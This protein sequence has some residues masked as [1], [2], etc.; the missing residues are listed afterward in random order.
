MI[1]G[2]FYDPPYVPNGLKVL[3]AVELSVIVM[4]VLA[5]A[6]MSVAV[7]RSNLTT[8][9]S[10]VILLNDMMC[11]MG[12]LP[13]RAY[14]LYGLISDDLFYSDRTNFGVRRIHD[15]FLSA[16]Y[17]TLGTIGLAVNL[18]SRYPKCN[19]GTRGSMIGL[20][21]SVAQWASSIFILQLDA[22]YKEVQVAIFF[23][24]ALTLTVS[25]WAVRAFRKNLVRLYGLNRYHIARKVDI[26][27][28]I[29]SLKTMQTLL[30][31]SA[32]RLTICT[33]LLAFIVFYQMAKCLTVDYKYTG[34]LHDILF[35][36]F[37]VIIPVLTLSENYTLRMKVSCSSARIVPMQNAL[38]DKI[39]LVNNDTD[40]HFTTLKNFWDAGCA[41]PEP[42]RAR[43]V[44]TPE[45]SVGLWVLSAVELV[46]VF[47]SLSTEV[48]FVVALSR[49][50][51]LTNLS[52]VLLLNECLCS[53]GSLSLRLITLVNNRQFSDNRADPIRMYHDFFVLT[54]YNMMGL[55]GIIIQVTGIV[56][57]PKIQM[58]YVFAFIGFFSVTTVSVV[59][60]IPF[61]R[62]L[63]RL[64]G[65]H[66]FDLRNKTM[67]SIQL[68]SLSIL[69]SALYLSLARLYIGA[70][71]LTIIY[72]YLAPACMMNA[73]R[74]VGALHDII[75]E[76]FDTIIPFWTLWNEPLLR[77]KAPCFSKRQSKN[78]GMRNALGQKISLSNNGDRYFEGLRGMWK[79]EGLITLVKIVYDSQYSY[80][81]TDPIRMY[82][83]FFV[84]TKYNMMGVSGII[85]YLFSKYTNANFGR[86]GLFYGLSCSTSAWTFAISGNLGDPQIQILYV[87]TL[88]GVFS[89]TTVSVMLTIPFKRHLSRLY[90]QHKFDL[91]SKTMIS[92]QLRSLSILKSALYL[93]LARLYIGAP[94]LTIIY[95]YMAPACMITGSRYVG[96]LHDIIFESFDTIIPFW[97]LWN[98]PLLR[99]KA[100]CFSRRRNKDVG[101][102]NAL[103]QKISL[104]N[105]GDKHFEEL[106]GM[107]ENVSGVASFG[108]TGLMSASPSK[109]CC[110]DSPDDVPFNLKVVS[111]IEL[112]VVVVSLYTTLIFTVSIIRY[113]LLTSLSKVLLLNE[114]FCSFGYL[115][116]RLI[117]LINVVFNSRYTYSKDDRMG[118]YHDFFVCSKY[119]MIAISG[120]MLYIFCKFT[121]SNFGCKGA[122]NGLLCTLISWVLSI[123][124]LFGDSHTN[125]YHL[126]LASLMFTVTAG[127]V[128]LTI[129]FK[130]QL[131]SL[132]FQHKFDLHNKTMISIQLRSLSIQKSVMYLSLVRLFIGLPILVFILAYMVPHC[133]LMES[134]YVGALHDIVFQ[135]FDI[136]I[137]FWIFWNEPLLRK[138]IPC[139]PAEHG[140]DMAMRN[141]LG[142]KISVINSGDRHFAELRQAGLPGPAFSR[143]WPA[144][145]DRSLSHA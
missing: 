94:I 63:S 127:S 139:R 93:S 34:M 59:L 32:V 130:S 2:C 144:A 132:Y 58:L 22:R 11:A 10:R 112:V 99:K 68:R 39:S 125:T 20:A 79:I 25:I 62:H 96:A 38:G 49:Y 21:V 6:A 33:C 141:A 43:S 28:Q 24:Y 104:S 134:R 106:K 118:L 31:L 41:F 29:R 136:A 90:S 110:C 129:P 19:F 13:T 92:I 115:S 75:F 97:T 78:V 53:F 140:K 40:A 87:I 15:Y 70:P 55:S 4:A 131:A 76:S 137:P 114:S 3:A 111:A 42:R 135:S 30:D 69:K 84:L 142:Q 88:A 89:V 72:A 128:V 65:Q 119:D 105:N 17:N 126:L 124:G 86:R 16:R 103:G 9:L 52:K 107:W 50:R 143:A 18:F 80:E 14:M 67:I 95:A 23:Y 81:R 44:Y 101:M 54:K 12:Y 64:Y 56:Y 57:D 61:K 100:P 91:R 73:S 116:L 121:N 71:I 46:I 51:L 145:L 85:L 77:K 102:R 98:E 123:V 66:K 48:I 108:S 8:N 109:A 37:D 5:L 36:A 117:I 122:F 133:L 45:I 26:S 7:Y 1:V 74:Y 27:I 82:H 138:K 47:V 83:D 35:E 113:R 120:I 60:T